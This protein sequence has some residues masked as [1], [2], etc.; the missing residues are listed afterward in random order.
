MRKLLSL[1]ALL[2]A[3]AMGEPVADAAVSGTEY[4]RIDQLRERETAEFTARESACYQRFAVND[5]LKELQ[6][7]HRAVLADLK[8]QEVLLHDR[9]RTQQAA[10]QLQRAEQKALEKQQAA[11]QAAAA[12]TV[13]EEKW[14]AQG[15]KQAAHAQNTASGSRSIVL[16]S[17]PSAAE[18]TANAKSYA[19]KQA[20]AEQKR[21]Q[22]AK[23]LKRIEKPVA[24]LPP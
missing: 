9:E 11:Q 19:A 7:A 12:A 24:P 20:A 5:C 4:Q 2:C 23:R 14:Q 15:A 8:H 17:G 21:Q 16:P 10:Q 1:L 18:R 3:P 22:V 6:P 13:A